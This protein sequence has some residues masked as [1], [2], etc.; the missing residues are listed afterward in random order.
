MTLACSFKN[1]EQKE[2]SKT[3]WPIVEKDK[4]LTIEPYRK[5]CN[6]FVPKQCLVING[7]T[8]CEG[9][10]GFKHKEGVWTKILVDVY[11]R[12]DGIQDVGQFG[13]ILKEILEEKKRN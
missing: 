7:K 8:E 3:K 10:E 1:A 12:P 13:Y 5:P 11:K 9:I 4:V 6:C 2:H